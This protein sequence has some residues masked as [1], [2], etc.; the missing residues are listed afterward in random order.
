MQD[1]TGKLHDF[2]ERWETKGQRQVDAADTRL[3]VAW[4]DTEHESQKLRTASA[5]GWDGAKAGFERSS[6]EL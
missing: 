6:H 2:T 4:T 3:H 5:E 1:W